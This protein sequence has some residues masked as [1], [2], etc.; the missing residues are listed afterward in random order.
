MDAHWS[1]HTAYL[2]DKSV[3]RYRRLKEAW[4]LR[5]DHGA[6]HLKQEMLNPHIYMFLPFSHKIVPLE[7]REVFYSQFRLISARDSF[8]R[9]F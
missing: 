7:S 3:Y 1:V 2:G 8:F 9:I 4:R 6:A 5:Q